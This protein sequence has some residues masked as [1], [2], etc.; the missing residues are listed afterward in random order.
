ML[1]RKI[2]TLSKPLDKRDLSYVSGTSSETSG[3]SV[4]EERS[5]VL[6]S[7]FVNQP[8]YTIHPTNMSGKYFPFRNQGIYITPHCLLTLEKQSNS[9]PQVDMVCGDIIP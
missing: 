5:G 2:Q 6:E 8:H 3:W 1:V 4:L 7:S 9:G